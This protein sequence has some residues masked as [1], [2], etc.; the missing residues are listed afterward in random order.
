M[1]HVEQVKEKQAGW[2]CICVNF[3]VV[4]RCVCV[5]FF[6]LDKVVLLQDVT[7]GRNRGKDPWTLLYFSLDLHVNL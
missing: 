1:N 2:D 3:Q 6:F 5:F 7:T 4:I